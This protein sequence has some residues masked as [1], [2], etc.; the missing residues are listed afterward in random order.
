MS[1]YD[2]ID[3][4]GLIDYLGVAYI[5]DENVD[6]MEDIEDLVD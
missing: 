5:D 4:D 2:E 6:N 3:N 1:A